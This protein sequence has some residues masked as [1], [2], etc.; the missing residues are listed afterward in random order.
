MNRQVLASGFWWKP[1]PLTRN[2]AVVTMSSYVLFLKN[3]KQSV[4]ISPLYEKRKITANVSYP[5][6]QYPEEYTQEEASLRKPLKLLF[7]FG[8][9]KMSILQN[10]WPWR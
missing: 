7:S 9:W 3:T 4:V 8:E 2:G 6:Q 10:K 5:V 1:M